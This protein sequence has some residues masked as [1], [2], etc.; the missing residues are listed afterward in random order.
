M[1]RVGLVGAVDQRHRWFL[2]A[3][4]RRRAGVR[5][6]GLS[7]PDPTARSRTADL[8]DLPSWADHR[9]LLAATKPSVVAIA[10]PDAGPVVIDALRADA[11][12]LVAPP[13]CDLLDELDTIAEL[14]AERGRR[15][16]AVHTYRGHPAARTAAEVLHRI[17]QPKLV[18][19]LLGGERDEAALRLSIMEAL[20][21]FGWLTGR[22]PMIEAVIT[23]GH[24][25]RDDDPVELRDSYGEL[26]LLGGVSEQTGTDRPADEP[27][28]EVRQQP[29]SPRREVIEINSDAGA[30][31]WDVGTGML[32]SVIDGQNPV[33]VSCGHPTEAEW[34]LNNL[35]RKREPVLSTGQSL[36]LTRTLLG[37]L[38]NA[39]GCWPD[40]RSGAGW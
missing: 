11:D 40:G 5:I 7:E 21:V 32:R 19:L 27:A 39:S 14:A 2:A 25:A 12:V 10:R 36:E 22:T 28:F 35:V 38:V 26:I 37:G 30:I 15:V 16:T 34:V 13:L 23:D 6:V 20:D 3:A 4:Q 33:T 9:E 8:Y 31:A 24:R 1:I 17:G 29:E 18:S